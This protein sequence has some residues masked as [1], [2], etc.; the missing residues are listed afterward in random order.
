MEGDIDVD[1]DGFLN[2]SEFFTAY[3]KL[4]E[5]DNITDVELSGIFEHFDDNHNGL[6][7]FQEFRTHFGETI[8]FDDATLIIEDE[9][10][11]RETLEAVKEEEGKV[12]TWPEVKLSV[13]NLGE[14][15]S[16]VIAL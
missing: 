11:L 3:K 7:D 1:K 10:V 8:D 6:V 4:I 15:N 14:Q 16:K 5:S 2:K 12:Y 13:E 9:K